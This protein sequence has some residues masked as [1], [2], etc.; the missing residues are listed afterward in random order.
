M[1]A[2]HTTVEPSSPRRACDAFRMSTRLPNEADIL[3]AAR[4]GTVR[5]EY[6]GR[7]GDRQIEFL[8]EDEY[9][10]VTVAPTA[11][12]ESEIRVFLSELLEIRF[13]GWETAEGSRG[14]FEWS[15]ELDTLDH[16]H[17]VPITEYRGVLI[18]ND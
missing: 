10:Q 6:E 15:V 17:E 8:Y 4:I 3:R 12:V 11:A 16:R 13:P 1:N 18:S 9:G 5:M 7:Y 2:S 14:S